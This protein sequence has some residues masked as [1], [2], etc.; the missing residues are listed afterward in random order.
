MS[1]ISEILSPEFVPPE[2]IEAINGDEVEEIETASQEDGITEAKK[3]KLDL[4]ENLDHIGIAIADETTKKSVNKTVLE[5][6]CLTWRKRPTVYDL[7]RKQ[8][9]EIVETQMHRITYR[10]MANPIDGEFTIGRV[11]ID[12][13]PTTF[14]SCDHPKCVGTT[15]RY[16]KAFFNVSNTPHKNSFRKHHNRRHC[17]GGARQIFATFDDLADQSQPIST[18]PEPTVSFS[19]TISA[20]YNTNT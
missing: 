3:F 9:L 10:T 19:S 2:E 18:T 8:M 17:E 5:K 11:Y 16:L 13:K 20:S 7:H 12:N 4:G 15:S 14:L 1:E 6:T